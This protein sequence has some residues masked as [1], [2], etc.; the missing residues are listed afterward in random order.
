MINIVYMCIGDSII[1][2]DIHPGIPPDLHPDYIL[3][4]IL[5]F[6]PASIW[7]IAAILT[8]LAVCSWWALCVDA[9]LKYEGIKHF[10]GSNSNTSI[11]T[12]HT[13]NIS[14]VE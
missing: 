12:I 8:V 10:H 5:G 13:V 2:V 1:I 14:I 7:S 9:Q 3:T 11:R 4:Y 6:S